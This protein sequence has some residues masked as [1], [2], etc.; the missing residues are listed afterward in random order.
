M[1][2]V[3]EIC[4]PVR[5]MRTSGGRCQDGF[6]PPRPAPVRQENYLANPKEGE[7]GDR[8]SPY[9]EGMFQIHIVIGGNYPSAPPKVSPPTAVVKPARHAKPP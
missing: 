8:P 6:P 9:S 2:F 3:V 4:G 5:A 7:S 1:D